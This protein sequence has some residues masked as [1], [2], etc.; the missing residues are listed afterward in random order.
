MGKNKVLEGAVWLSFIMVLF[1]F[2]SFSF[3]FVFVGSRGLN[4][5]SPT[6]SK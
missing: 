4:L 2:F 3:S 6:L 1:L 5:T